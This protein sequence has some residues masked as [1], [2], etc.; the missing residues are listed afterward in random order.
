M[1]VPNLKG[2]QNCFFGHAIFKKS[3]GQKH[4]NLES[5]GFDMWVF[6]WDRIKVGV[7]DLKV[8]PKIGFVNL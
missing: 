2:F 1:M 4:D 3:H 8:G 7:R 6:H 5:V